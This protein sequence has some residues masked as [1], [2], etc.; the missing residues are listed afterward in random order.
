MNNE[1]IKRL[2]KCQDLALLILE[3]DKHKL[4][5]KRLLLVLLTIKDLDKRSYFLFVKKRYG[6]NI[7]PFYREIKLLIYRSLPTYEMIPIT[8]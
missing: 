8:T 2:E 1:A 5:I 4:N 3:I 7:R 6:D